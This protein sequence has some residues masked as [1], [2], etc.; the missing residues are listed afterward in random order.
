[1]EH[2]PGTAHSDGDHGSNLGDGNRSLAEKRIVAQTRVQLLDL[3]DQRDHL[4][5]RIVAALRRAGMT[6]TSAHVNLDLHAPAMSAVHAQIGWLR[7]HHAI[8]PDTVFLENVDPRQ[9]VAVF[10]LHRSHDPQ[11]V[12][13]FQL[14]ILYHLARVNHAGHACALIIGAASV[15]ET[16]LHF[17]LVR[18]P[19]PFLRI[20]NTDGVDVRVH[21]D[22][23]FA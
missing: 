3:R 17:A 6:R 2:A 23:A 9:A 11:R 7:E 4:V 14:Q 1:M 19:G 13:A 10:F 20:A 12:V 18:V 22:H 15:D 5:N 16:I 21:H 8:R